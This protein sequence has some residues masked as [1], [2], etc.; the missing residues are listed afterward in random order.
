V[1]E[2]LETDPTPWT[3]L[4]DSLGL[5]HMAGKL[6]ELIDAV[7]ERMTLDQRITVAGFAMVATILED[8]INEIQIRLAEL[9]EQRNG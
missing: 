6:Q 8:G 5:G 7:D 4:S 3:D 9:R 2:R 1:S